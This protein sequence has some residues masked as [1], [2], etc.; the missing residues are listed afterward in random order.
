MSRL[1]GSEKGGAGPAG[2]ALDD[3][4]GPA[5]SLVVAPD[6]VAR[7]EALAVPFVERLVSARL[8]SGAF[9]RAIAAIDGLGDRE[10]Q[11]TT[12][13]ARGFQD[14][15]AGTLRNVLA[16][17]APL[18]RN[19]R[20]LRQ[21]AERLGT[22]NAHRHAQPAEQ[23]VERELARAE[24]RLRHLVD[25]L[26]SDRQTLEGDNAAIA[27]QELALWT[28]IQTLRQYA[29]LAAR[30]D[31]LLDR[32]ID[33][34]ADDDP[35]HGRGLR[36]EAQYAVR[37]RRRDLLLQL[38]VA[39]QGYSAL[40]VIEQDNLDVIWAIRAATTTT[41]TALRTALFTG[42]TLADRRRS[43][44]AGGRRIEGA[45]DEVLGAVDEVNAR[46]RRTLEEIAARP[47]A[48]DA[49]LRDPVAEG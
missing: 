47:A 1:S 36:D 16:D 24:P 12:A 15:P 28:E 19:L 40:R 27:Q 26:E 4:L 39:T 23:E 49:E 13:I 43:E 33:A 45:W 46:K 10:I 29:A 44:Q 35:A 30:L 21:I 22:A 48:T 38:A 7:I 3:V 41:V 9:R 18:S 31:A 32:Q 6:V 37:R 14:R 42:R 8:G 5:G 25:A 20:S 2:P 34:I 17:D 11:A